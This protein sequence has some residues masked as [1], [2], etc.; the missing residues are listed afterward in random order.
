[1]LRLFMLVLLFFTTFWGHAAFAAEDACLSEPVKNGVADLRCW[2]GYSRISLKGKWGFDYQALNEGVAFHGTAS[3]PLRWRE[4]SPAL[5]FAGRG[6][7]R[8]KL[9]LSEPM[10]HLALKLSTNYTARKVVIIDAAGQEK[11]LFDTGNTDLSSRTIVKM[12]TPIIP[13][14][15]L[16]E[17]SELI[18]YVNST[19]TINAGMEVAPIIGSADDLLRRDQVLKNSATIISAILIVFFAVNIFLWWVRDKD[20]S[21]LSLAL[22][23]FVVV[24]RQLAASGVLYEF[25]PQLTTGFDASIGWGTFFGGSIFGMIFFRATYPKIVPKWLAVAV[26]LMASSG[27][28]IL[29]FQPQPVMQVYGGYINLI[30]LFAI[31]VLLAYLIRN[32]PHSDKEL[33]LTIFSCSALLCGFGAD[34]IYYKVVGFNPAIPLIAFGM[35]VFVG[36]QSIIISRRYTQSLKRSAEL[37]K[38]LQAS[39]TN[40]EGKVARRT[41]ELA[42]KNKELEEMARTDALTKL[43]NRR[44]FD[45]LIHHE[46][47]RSQRSGQSFVVG[48]IDL[49]HF[50]T[51]NDTYGHDVGDRVLQSVAKTLVDGLRAGDFPFRWGGDEFCILFPETPGDVALV[52]AERLKQAIESQTFHF[53][54]DELTLTASFGLAIW[55][56]DCKVSDV[57]KHA[58]QAMYESKKQ[59]SNKVTAWWHMS[60]RALSV[61]E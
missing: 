40:L 53:D 37:A 22:M 13:V 24:V 10:D 31:I 14:A 51:V 26:Y 43:S 49:D 33:Q 12:R 45:E 36:S 15:N 32:L 57:I 47:G 30:A 54:G 34:V 42:L 9:L 60:K 8:I 7:Y 44:S 23:T 6:V 39:N 58:D 59:G 50:K 35:M 21:L 17:R 16:G 41:A 3:V 38:E 5:P 29:I 18:I 56:A 52:I 25:M 27:F 48:I 55:Q 1:M 61:E 20:L 19:E 2:D 4:M 46:V 11:I 28:L